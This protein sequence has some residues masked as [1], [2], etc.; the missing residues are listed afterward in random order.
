MLDVI[1]EA[2]SGHF[3]LIKCPECND[4]QVATVWHTV[5]FFSY[6]HECECGYIITESDW[7][8]IDDI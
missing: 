6:M 3:E 4:N 7:N 1:N 8:K 2:E 5:P